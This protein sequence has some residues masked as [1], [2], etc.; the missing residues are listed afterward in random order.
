MKKTLA[1]LFGFLLLTT[2][3]GR[4]QVGKILD[5]L[6]TKMPGLDEIL[7]R[8]PAI[9]TSFADA[10]YL[11]PFLDNFDP[12]EFLPL[13]SLKSTPE[14]Y[15]EC[16][17]GLYQ[18]KVES[19]CLQSATRAPLLEGGGG[20]VY[21]PI[22]G[23]RAKLVS[24]I[25]QRTFRH[26]EIS[27]QQVQEL[28]WAVITYTNLAEMSPERQ[29][30]ASV[31]MT[32]EEIAAANRDALGLLA[33]DKAERAIARLSPEA[34]RLLRAEDRIRATLTRAGSTY[35]ELER[36]AVLPA[37]GPDEEEA[38]RGQWS[39]RPEG[40]FVRYSTWGFREVCVEFYIPEAF[41][42]ETDGL[43][44]IVLLADEAGNRIEIA[45]DETLAPLTVAGEPAMKGYAFRGIKLA[46]V[47]PEEPGKVSE[48]AYES[49]G[50]TFAGVPAGRRARAIR[51]EA[52]RY[53]GAAD[54]LQRAK[55]HR[56]Q[57][58]RLDRSYAHHGPHDTIFNLFH[59]EA[60]LKD[61]VGRADKERRQAGHLD[62][63][64][65][66]WMYLV[67]NRELY[68]AKEPVEDEVPANDAVHRDAASQR[69][70]LRMIL[71]NWNFPPLLPDEPRPFRRPMLLLGS[72]R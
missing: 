55:E 46:G 50:W 71:K 13:D 60:A 59:L 66:A 40:V 42:I 34:A 56:G 30:V 17:P 54:R 39:L 3:G 61:A 53:A 2:E 51:V 68:G 31:L 47:D 33:E 45:Y 57:L 35:E 70:M 63:V 48:A 26:P 41:Q 11:V 23:P 19:Y 69:L 12:R 38:P 65:K 67:W 32:E 62:L 16:L 9:T 14:G 4:G 29:R 37:V 28:L 49:S 21:A 1:V 44:R 18:V 43:G 20:Y 7:G 6:Q 52:G 8:G 64:K 10:V 25:M 72:V 27:Q 22:K 15:L 24:N 58:E 5:K 36:I